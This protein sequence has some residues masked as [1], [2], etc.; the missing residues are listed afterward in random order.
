[1]ADTDQPP[2]VTPF[3]DL[4]PADRRELL[5][6]AAINAELA[7]GNQERTAERAKRNV[8]VRIG[9]IVVG[10]AVLIGGLVMLVLPGPGL[11]GIIVGLGLLARELAWAERLLE[12]VKK[13]A[14]LDELKE[15]PAWVKV[16][17]WVGTIAAVGASVTYVVLR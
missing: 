17:M 4:S 10:F 11:V 9:T 8:F 1:M 2:T 6:Q 16:A 5:R 3:R 15:Q 13:R 12:Y 7:T 14:K